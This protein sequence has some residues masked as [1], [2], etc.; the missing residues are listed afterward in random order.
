M[1]L[2]LIKKVNLSIISDNL[3]SLLKEIS[4]FLLHIK[5]FTTSIITPFMGLFLDLI[6]C[7]VGKASFSMLEIFALLPLILLI[8]RVYQRTTTFI[9]YR[10]GYKMYD[11][12]EHFIETI[13]YTA[14]GYAYF[15]LVRIIFSVNIPLIMNKYK[16]D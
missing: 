8:L 14:Y 16:Y 4:K 13:F 3:L 12:I 2:Q 9:V 6:N 5:I 10:G 15:S 7:L 11:Y 1:T